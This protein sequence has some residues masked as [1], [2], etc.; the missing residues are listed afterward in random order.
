MHR[1]PAL[2]QPLRWYL[3]SRATEFDSALACIAGDQDGC[4]FVK[5]SY[6]M[7]DLPAMAADGV[8]PGP[9]IYGQWVAEVA[10]RIVQ[11]AAQPLAENKT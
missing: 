3:G 4:E 5:P 9:A 8:P 7:M 2:P 6:A 1:F 10:R 11:R